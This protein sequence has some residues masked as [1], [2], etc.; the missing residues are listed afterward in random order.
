MGEWEGG[1]GEPSYEGFSHSP[2]LPLSHSL[3]FIRVSLTP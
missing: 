2:L 3:S 1:K